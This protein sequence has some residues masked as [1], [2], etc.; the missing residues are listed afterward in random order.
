MDI[1]P[2]EEFVELVTDEDPREQ[3]EPEVTR[4]PIAVGD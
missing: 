2:V 3:L 1:G 4:E